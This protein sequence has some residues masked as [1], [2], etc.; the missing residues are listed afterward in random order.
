MKVFAIRKVRTVL[1]KNSSELHL[2]ESSS[3]T[4][5]IFKAMAN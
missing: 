4:I 2:P 1:Q 5:K 3:Y